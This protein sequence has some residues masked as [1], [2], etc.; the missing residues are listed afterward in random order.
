MQLNGMARWAL[1]CNVMF[2]LCCATVMIA[3]SQVVAAT[4][5]GTGS[6]DEDVGFTA[7]DVVRFIGVGLVLFAGIVACV[8]TRP[9][10]IRWQVRTISIADFAWVA[11][12]AVLVL[13][14]PD[15][16]V[17]NGRA[18]VLTVALIVLGFGIWQWWASRTK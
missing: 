17:P 13:G 1:L 8:A 14:L 7:V 11:A 15:L 9:Q 5:V 4:L 18:L 10:P 12:S 2:S 16:L 6:P 3:G